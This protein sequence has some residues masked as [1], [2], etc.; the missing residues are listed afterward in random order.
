M[1]VATLLASPAFAGLPSAQPAQVDFDG[2]RIIRE[3]VVNGGLIEARSDKPRRT[4]FGRL[5][6]SSSALSS[7][8]PNIY[9]E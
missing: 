9:G 4:S 6:I 3:A 5:R 2:Q 1:T 7:A 8:G